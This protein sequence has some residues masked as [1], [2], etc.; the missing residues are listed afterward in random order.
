MIVHSVKRLKNLETKSSEK[1]AYL[2]FSIKCA[3]LE[4]FGLFTIEF[5]L[6]HLRHSML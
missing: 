6:L 4:E 1:A 2:G 5:A 3:E